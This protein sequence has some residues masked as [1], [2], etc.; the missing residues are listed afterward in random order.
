MSSRYGELRK[1]GV[2]LRQ[3]RNYFPCG[4]KAKLNLK[5]QKKNNNL[6]ITKLENEHNHPSDES[7]SE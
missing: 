7:K 3:Y 6:I 4:C 5:F 1:W 2:G